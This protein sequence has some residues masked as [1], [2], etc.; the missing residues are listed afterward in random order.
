MD[1]KSKNL[2]VLFCAGSLFS[3]LAT[4]DVNVFRA[5]DRKNA[6]YAKV[7]DAQW[8]IDEDGLSTF[9]A[10]NFI[11]PGKPCKVRFTVVGVNPPFNQGDQ[12]PI[13]NMAG[14]IGVY[15]PQHGGLGHW[16]ITKDPA[17]AVPAEI[18]NFVIANNA[19]E[20][21]VGYT[22]GSPSQCLTPAQ[23]N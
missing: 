11:V 13:H 22:G 21:N 1:M 4:A 20:V 17:P 6:T 12:G 3:T 10:A 7:A 5:I 16:S 18:T 23:P 14:Y 9:E 19:A 15:S 8:R 2:I